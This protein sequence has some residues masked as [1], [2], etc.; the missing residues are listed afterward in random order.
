MH[1]G[2]AS[3]VEIASYL[4]HAPSMTLDTYSHVIADLRGAERTPAD[5]QIW[6]ARREIRP[7][8]GPQ[9]DRAQLADAPE[10]EKT[11]P[12]RGLPEWAIQDSNL[13]PLPYQRSQGRERENVI[14]HHRHKVAGNRCYLSTGVRRP[15]TAEMIL[16]YPFGTSRGGSGACWSGSC[17]ITLEG[18]RHLRRVAVGVG[19]RR[20]TSR[21]PYGRITRPSMGSDR[22]PVLGEAEPR[23]LSGYLACACGQGPAH[24]VVSGVADGAV[25]ADQQSSA[26]Q[27]LAGCQ[28]RDRVLANQFSVD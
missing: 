8:S 9:A 19:T 27:Q 3:V 6:Q 18:Q 20:G 28:S 12:E 25:A 14:G 1:E 7:K 5:E 23:L 15:R 21:V 11:P 16:T 10:N 24:G 13:G 2:Q 17:G 26:G 4:G 22:A